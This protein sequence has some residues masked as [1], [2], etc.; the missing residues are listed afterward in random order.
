MFF[1]LTR[2]V[3]KRFAMMF[4]LGESLIFGRIKRFNQLCLLFREQKDP[5][6]HCIGDE[7][8]DFEPFKSWLFLLFWNVIVFILKC[9][10]I[11]IV[12]KNFF[13]WPHIWQFRLIFL[14]EKSKLPCNKPIRIWF[15]A[16]C[17]QVRQAFIYLVYLFLFFYFSVLCS[18]NSVC[19]NFCLNFLIERCWE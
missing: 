14:A 2:T 15:R 16:Q 5:E 1:L 4:S 18:P 9:D 3:K 10:F 8:G 17:N 7:F 6:K 13:H 12:S 11:Y 19:S